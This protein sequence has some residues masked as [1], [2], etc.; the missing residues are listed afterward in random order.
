MRENVDQNNSEQGHFSRSERVKKI[1]IFERNNKDVSLYKV[2][3]IRFPFVKA[4]TTATS[5]G[6]SLIG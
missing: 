1:Q 6:I 3:S 2:L 4:R 5:Q